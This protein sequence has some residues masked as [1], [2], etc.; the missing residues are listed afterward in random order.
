MYIYNFFTYNH[1]KVTKNLSN[2]FKTIIMYLNSQPQ[3]YKQ[4]AKTA[5]L[6]LQVIIILSVKLIGLTN[7]SSG[8]SS[9]SSLATAPSSSFGFAFKCGASGKPI[10]FRKSAAVTPVL[11]YTKKKTHHITREQNKKQLFH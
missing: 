10:R 9:T 7:K 2:N 6:I 4:K 8:N 1:I 11:S 3:K 5:T